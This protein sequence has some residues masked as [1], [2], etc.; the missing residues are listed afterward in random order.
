MKRSIFSLSLI[1]YF[2]FSQISAYDAINVIIDF[3]SRN[4]DGMI[5]FVETGDKSKIIYDSGKLVKILENLIEENGKS[6]AIEKIKIEKNYIKKFLT[7]GV[8]LVGEGHNSF[9]LYTSNEKDS[10]R[11][12]L[13]KEDEGWRV[14][15]LDPF[16]GIKYSFGNYLSEEEYVEPKT[17]IVDIGEWIKDKNYGLEFKVNDYSI[18]WDNGTPFVDVVLK[19]RNTEENVG[20]DFFDARLLD[21]DNYRTKPA[22]ERFFE[23][24]NMLTKGV[25]LGP[26]YSSKTVTLPFYAASVTGYSVFLLP[27]NDR[28]IRID[29]GE[30]PSGLF[31]K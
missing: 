29:L 22:K 6:G 15:I 23:I 18:S 21:S 24:N 11:F 13:T 1:P 5:Y 20:Y 4:Y 25:F 31:P 14:F 27:T 8:T 2:L 26:E 30:I 17:K 7:Y 19:V 16:T 28:R 12:G 3:Y 9:M 10:C